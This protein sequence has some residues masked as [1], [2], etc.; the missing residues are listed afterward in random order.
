[1]NYYP[2]DIELAVHKSHGALRPGNG[3]AFSV[4][5]EKQECL[6]VINELKSQPKD[7]F[8]TREI[9]EK[10]RQDLSQEF[11]IAVHSIILIEPNTI[12][13]TSSGK[14]RR[15]SCKNAYLNGE[16]SIVDDWHSHQAALEDKPPSENRQSRGMTQVEIEQWLISSVSGK[17]GLAPEMIDSQKSFVYYGL[18]S[19]MSLEMTED[20]SALLGRPVPADSVYNYPTIV[21]LSKWLGREDKPPE[22]NS[23]NILVEV[24]E[25]SGQEDRTWAGHVKAFTRQCLSNRCDESITKKVELQRTTPNQ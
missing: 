23:K 7:T 16:L 15:Q 3:A 11:G 13:K 19:I 14:I 12:L 25:P 1:M 22:T 2:Q 21:F 24:Y 9:I 17:L 8:N 20:L 10:I 6:V 5:Q 4:V 18:D